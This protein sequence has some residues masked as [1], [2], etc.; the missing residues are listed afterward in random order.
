MSSSIG[1]STFFRNLP[2]P[3]Q[4]RSHVHASGRTQAW[5]PG[6]WGV[7]I[8]QTGKQD[9]HGFS[10]A[11]MKRASETPFNVP[12]VGCRSLNHVWWSGK[13]RA[14]ADIDRGRCLSRRLSR[15]SGSLCGGQPPACQRGLLWEVVLD[16]TVLGDERFNVV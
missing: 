14:K 3:L 10:D 7:S 5:T 13:S 12:L 4:V 2:S 16:L 9:Y 6:I 1:N 11:Q 8:I 15:G